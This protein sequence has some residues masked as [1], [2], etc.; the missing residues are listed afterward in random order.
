MYEIGTL[1]IYGRTG[2]C[3]VERVLRRE[4][5]DYYALKLLYQGCDIYA[6]V[7]SI[8]RRLTPAEA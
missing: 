4:G 2:V 1:V 3:R 8:S 7:N 6:P 5:Q